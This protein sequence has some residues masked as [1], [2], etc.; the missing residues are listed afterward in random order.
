MEEEKPVTKPIGR[1]AVPLR[2]YVPEFDKEVKVEY[3]ST[4]KYLVHLPSG[5]DRKTTTDMKEEGWEKRGEWQQ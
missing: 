1:Q 2:Y 3:L 4:G 5:L